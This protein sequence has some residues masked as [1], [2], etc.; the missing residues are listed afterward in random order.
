MQDGADSI[1]SDPQ[2]PRVP[3]DPDPFL[4][5]FLTL[6]GKKDTVAMMDPVHKHHEGSARL[7]SRDDPSRQYAIPYYSYDHYVWLVDKGPEFPSVPQ[8]DST[9]T[10]QPPAG[11]SIPE[12]FYTLHTEAETIHVKNLGTAGW[13]Q[14]SGR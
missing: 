13:H 1:A 4:R 3:H 8:H 7:V 11:V 9:I 6:P 10:I 2:M 12:G 14:V 5:V